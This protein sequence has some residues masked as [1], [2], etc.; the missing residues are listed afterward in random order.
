VA[1]S[2]VRHTWKANMNKALRQLIREK[3]ADGRL[4]HDSIPRTWGSPGN[5]ETCVA[6]G[7]RIGKNQ[8]VMERLDAAFKGIQFHVRCFCYWDTE[9]RPP[10]RS[11]GRASSSAS[12]AERR[13]E[14]RG[15]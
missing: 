8:F 13:Q 14:A 5:D 4:P 7:L 11:P 2:H 9:R 6:C 10:G 15:A 3:L 12:G 1:W